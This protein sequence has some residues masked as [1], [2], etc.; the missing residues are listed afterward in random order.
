MDN[1]ND[2]TLRDT[3]RGIAIRA[4]ILAV[5]GIFVGGWLAAGALK[6]AGTVVK[7]GA[8]TALV[9]I[10][11]GMAA[12]EVKKVQRRFARAETQPALL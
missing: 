9:L 11:G 12:W 5:G 7:V 1:N 10:G 4:G 6:A 2:L 8:G 3:A